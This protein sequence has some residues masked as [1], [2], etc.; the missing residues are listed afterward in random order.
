MIR[1]DVLSIDGKND[2]V[3]TKAGNLFDVK[4][5][6]IHSSGITITCVV[7]IRRRVSIVFY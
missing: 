3:D 1:S 5:R 4:T 7:I 2:K 6:P